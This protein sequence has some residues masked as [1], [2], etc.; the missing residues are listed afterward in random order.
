M[1]EEK[2]NWSTRKVLSRAAAVLAVLIAV[3]GVR[4][5]TTGQMPNGS[6]APSTREVSD[7]DFNEILNRIAW[8]DW[9]S[10]ATREK[11]ISRYPDIGPK[12][13]DLMWTLEYHGYSDEHIVDC[14]GLFDKGKITAHYTAEGME[15][16][17]GSLLLCSPYQNGG[18][19][20]YP[21]QRRLR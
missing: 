11:F 10:S 7:Q 20:V 15:V 3:Y 6:P 21:S 12:G 4:Y 5:L 19:D 18:S 13:V 14:L 2:E 9:L 16:W 8:D 17:Q 1:E